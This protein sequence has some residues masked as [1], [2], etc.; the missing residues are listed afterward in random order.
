MEK[1][2]HTGIREMIYGLE[3]EKLPEVLQILKEQNINIE[4]YFV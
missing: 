4:V 3:E 2:F 1:D